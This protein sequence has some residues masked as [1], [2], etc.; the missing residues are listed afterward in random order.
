MSTTGVLRGYRWTLMVLM[1][2]CIT[3]C[4]A[5][6][7][8]AGT[9]PQAAGAGHD[10]RQPVPESGGSLGLGLKN[11]LI[12]STGALA[13]GAYGMSQWWQDGFAGQFRTRKEGWLGQGTEYGGADKLGHSFFAYATARLMTRGFEAAGNADER[14]RRLG[15]WSVL[16]VMMGVEVL[17]GYSKK[18]R[19]SGEDAV[20]NIAGVGLAYAMETM[21]AL[22]RLVDYRLLYKPSPGSGYEPGG[23]YSGQTYLL[24]LKANGLPPWREHPV[25]RYVEFAVG[26]GTR[27]YEDT[28]RTDPR[29]DLYV[30]LS[31]NV[32]EVLAR[33]VFRG[34]DRSGRARRAADLL[35][36]FAQVP[37]TAVLKRHR[38]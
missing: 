24:V 31:L 29:R 16:G 15:M 20:M 12:I 8:D 27:G 26:Y 1:A 22:D 19:F 25:M 34:D 37:G 3:V 21:P 23:D 17:D 4:H 10:S 13:V 36:E 2:L 30:G 5:E 11:S 38:L 35:L 7:G 28:P 9:A 14:A 32:S 18:Y 33:T 6:S